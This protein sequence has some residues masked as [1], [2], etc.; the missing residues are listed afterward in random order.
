M[1]MKLFK[2]V[3]IMIVLLFSIQIP[4]AE[5]ATL[6][7][8]TTVNLNVRATPSTNG[9]LIQTLKKG[10]K[11]KYGTYNKEWS[12]IYLNSRTYYASAQYIKRIATPSSTVTKQAATSTGVTTVNLN[13]RVSAH[14]KAT[15]YRTLKKGT[16]VQ[17]AVHNSSWAKV[18]IGGKTYYAA[19]AYIAPKVVASTPTVTKEDGYANRSLKLFGER[20]QRSTVLKV[21]PVKSKVVS[22]K[23]NTS[24]SIV[25]LGNETFFTPTAWITSGAPATPPVT[26][27]PP[28]VKTDG[29][30]NREL[31]LFGQRNQRSTVLKVLPI[32]SKVVSSKY[33]TS[34][35]VVYLGNETYYTPTVGI[36]TGAPPV[37]KP[38][39]AKPPVIQKVQGYANRNANLYKKTLQSSPVARV[40]PKYTTVT[41]SKHNSS[42]SVVYIGTE[43]FYTPTSWLTAGKAPAA[44]A[45]TPK[46]KVYT[47]TPGDVLNVRASASASSAVLGR[48]AHGTQVDHYGSANGFYKIKY[49]GRDGYISTAYAMTLKP[50]AT[51]GA[52]IVLDAGHGGGDPGAVN[53]S[54][55][56]KTIVLDVTKRVETYLRSKYGYQVRLTRSTDVYLT[57]DQRVQTAKTLRGNLFVS[58]HTNAATTP[59]AKGVET[60][61]SSYSAHSAKSRV[62]AT[63]IQ[64]NLMGK[65][66]GM[67]NRGVKTANY[68]V[69]SYNT[70]PSALVELGFISS[71]QDVTHLR[72]NTSRQRMAEGVAEG[73]AQ[74]VRAYH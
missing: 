69:I 26:T 21:L 8:E 55:Y 61:Y 41:Y 33:N 31:K 1:N 3:L 37:A 30:A 36:T 10:T 35:S 17:Y 22:S 53:G 73:I 16:T 28:V 20:N 23:Y 2:L 72:N 27:K 43:T 74:Y 45:A 70:M 39:V 66:S 19:K 6:E 71:P 54:L 24:W 46:G 49:N 5:A 25:Y 60:F 63:N 52:V 56:E 44:P 7:G 13:I 29:Y 64:S 50:N 51:S 14:S 9:K 34:W 12:K 32:K 67:T 4:S 11:V 62:L 59:A 58:L 42:W 47:N 57:L 65:M 38:P 40:L 68:Y 18:Y 15:V 48:L